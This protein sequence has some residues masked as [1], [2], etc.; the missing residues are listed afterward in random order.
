MKFLTK[1]INSAIF[2]MD[3]TMFDTE[4]L[5]IEMIKEASLQIYG[6]RMSDD[7]LI[8][9]LG[10]NAKTAEDMAKE[11][12][13]ADYPYKEIR[14]KS[15][16]LE[17]EYIRS[18]G[19]PVKDGLY[20]VLERLKKNEILIALATSSKRSIVTEYLAA[21]NVMQFFNIIICGDEVEHG[22]PDPEIF[23]KAAFE[24]NC[25]PAECLIFEDSENGLLSASAAGGIPIFIKDIKEPVENIKKLAYKS[26]G[27]MI[28]YLDDLVDFTTKM[29]VPKLNEHFPQSSGYIRAGIHGFGAIGG[30]YLTQVFN[31][32]DGYTRPFEIVGATRNASLRKLINAYGNFDVKYGSVAY[33]QNIRNVKIIDLNNQEEM[34]DMYMNMHIIGLSVPETA[35]KAQ[36]DVIAKGLIARYDNG[37]SSL[38]ILIVMNK[39]KAARFVKKHVENALNL[40]VDEQKTKEIIEKTYFCETVVNRMVSVITEKTILEEYK[41]NILQLEKNLANIPDIKSVLSFYSKRQKQLRS[42]KARL[43]YDIEEFAV[44]LNAISKYTSEFSQFKISLFNSEPDML[45]YAGNTSPLVKRL[46]QIEIS[47]QIGKMQN[48]KN[49]ISN[50]THAIIAWYSS[51]LGYKSIG[52]G[53]G[54]ERVL[55]IVKT[56]MKKE[57]MPA[58]VKENPEFAKY[59]NEFISSFIKR[60]RVS[61]K[62]KC[63]RVG[64]DPLRKLQKGERI[65]GTIELAKKY[66]IDTPM[67]E[68]GVACAIYY[69]IADINPKDKDCRTI[70]A[71]Y[72][73]NKSLKEVLVYS[74][75]YNGTNYKGLNEEKDAMLISR[76]EVAFDSIKV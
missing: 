16:I 33:T 4:R 15:D 36:A 2:D 8:A 50:G 20:D 31:H 21:A 39:L 73:K 46:R 24:L 23:L 12:Y 51:I 28:E 41:N 30:G 22:K 67:L 65:F 38:T 52:Q 70:K 37:G 14:I 1:N 76:I 48:I 59:I 61:F 32:W 45:M 71:L 55:S 34:I 42:K 74:G 9:S 11:Y 7:L 58:L 19:V 17:T 62:D 26:Y 66:E 44:K 5:R 69:A 35:I 27:S 56:I 49:K 13:G 63:T 53:M 18:N 64:R 54:D 40:I 72:E 47:D 29:P 60:C 68:F 10:V 3:G 75:D 25:D 43:N 6:E 57:I